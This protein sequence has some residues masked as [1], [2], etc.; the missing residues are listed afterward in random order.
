MN[1]IGH[2][3][4]KKIQIASIVTMSVVPDLM[5]IT[6]KYFVFADMDRLLTDKMYFTREVSGL[7]ERPILE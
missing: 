6:L 2:V 5:T 3:K 7:T 4:L 1:T